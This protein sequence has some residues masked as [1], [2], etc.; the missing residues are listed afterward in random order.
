MASFP[1]EGG[2][3]VMLYRVFCHHGVLEKRD[4]TVGRGEGGRRGGKEGG[5]EGGGR[6][7]GRKGGREGGKEEVEGGAGR[8]C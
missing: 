4:K 3:S 5:R 6:E 2:D 8:Y 7:R 1:G